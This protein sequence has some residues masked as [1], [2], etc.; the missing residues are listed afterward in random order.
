MNHL[1]LVWARGG[2][3][4]LLSALPLTTPMAAATVHPQRPQK[5]PLDLQAAWFDVSL[6]NI[7]I[8]TTCEASGYASCIDYE[9]QASHEQ[10]CHLEAPS[11]VLFVIRYTR[12]ERGWAMMSSSTC[13]PPSTRCR[14]W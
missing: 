1:V 10:H 5:G 2:M 14:G 12:S 13:R 11:Y 7:A 8:N 3:L 9:A 6:A 4:V